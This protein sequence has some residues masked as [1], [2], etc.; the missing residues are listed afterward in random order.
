MVHTV[1]PHYALFDLNAALQKRGTKIHLLDAT[2][3]VLTL[4]PFLLLF[5][6]NQ[7]L[8]LINNFLFLPYVSE[9]MFGYTLFI[10]FKHHGFVKHWL[11][12]NGIRGKQSRVIR[13]ESAELRQSVLALRLRVELLK[14]I[15]G[16]IVHYQV[17]LEYR[18]DT[19]VRHV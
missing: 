4:L 9:Q 15:V 3:A 19:I 12:H 16:L 17:V 11:Q 10:M 8:L 1:F 6:L 2:T 7:L 5:H 14:T 13:V 18:H